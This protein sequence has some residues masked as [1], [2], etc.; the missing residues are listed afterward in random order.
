M[1]A[2]AVNSGQPVTLIDA[3]T[4]V[5]AGLAVAIPSTI[6][7]HT[8]YIKGN[9]AVGAGAIQIRTAD[10]PDYTGLWSPVGTPITVVANAEVHVSIEGVF[11]AL[12]ADISTT[13]TVG[14]ATVL[15]V[16]EES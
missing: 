10:T 15:Y 7:R 13:V 8:F 2:Y 12:R 3:Q 5:A 6:K 1:V 4:A 14:T 9:G 16:G 11:G